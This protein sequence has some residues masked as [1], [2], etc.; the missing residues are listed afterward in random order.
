MEARVGFA[1]KRSGRSEWQRMSSAGSIMTV[2]DKA[3]VRRIPFHPCPRLSSHAF[4]F[5][6]CRF[7]VEAVDRLHWISFLSRLTKA[8]CF[9]KVLLGAHVRRYVSSLSQAEKPLRAAHTL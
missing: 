9:T 7:F 4:L 6:L 2:R 1:L 5:D 8:L 3:G